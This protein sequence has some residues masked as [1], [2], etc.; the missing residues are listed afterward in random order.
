MAWVERFF[1][2]PGRAKLKYASIVVDNRYYVRESIFGLSASLEC[3]LQLGG[4]AIP[5]MFEK[6]RN[7][8]DCYRCVAGVQL[9]NVKDGC[10]FN[11]P[12][13]SPRGAGME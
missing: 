1:A 5:T 12:V 13:F 6:S 9:L 4:T 3:F 8:N 10:K 7:L 11:K 2:K